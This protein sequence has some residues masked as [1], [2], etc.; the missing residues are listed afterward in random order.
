M[1]D[2]GRVLLIG[3]FRA[4]RDY[5]GHEDGRAVVR[6]PFGHGHRDKQ[7]IGISVGS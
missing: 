6:A 4:S 1:G 7:T 3:W 5:S 2:A